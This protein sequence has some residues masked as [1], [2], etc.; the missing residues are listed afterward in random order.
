M[1]RIA[2][3]IVPVMNDAELAAVIDDHYAGEVQ[4]LTTGA[5]S[6]LLKLASLRGGSPPNRPTGGRRSPPRTCA[7]RHWA[8][9]TAAP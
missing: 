2:E 1:N 9:R 3:R 6:G 8:A 7:P 5:E 4:T